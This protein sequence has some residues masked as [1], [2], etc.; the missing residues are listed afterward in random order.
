MLTWGDFKMIE[1][2]PFMGAM[3][4][5]W[6]GDRPN[7]MKKKHGGPKGQTFMETYFQLIPEVMVI[8]ASP[9]GFPRAP[10]GHKRVWIDTRNM[11]YCSSCT[12][13]RQGKLWKSFET[14]SG[15]MAKGKLFFPNH[16]GTPAW[17]WDYVHCHD[18]QADR[19]TQIFHAET[20]VGGYHNDFDPS[21]DYYN[22]FLTTSAIARLGAA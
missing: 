9:T 10:V 5:N 13:D 6:Q 7:W 11:M 18:I 14:G 1:R 16:D 2:R 3:A 22:R 19:M 20:C 17:S 12:F 4:D 8:E 21:Y 15:R